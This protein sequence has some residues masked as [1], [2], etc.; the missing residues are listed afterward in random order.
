MFWKYNTLSTSQ[1]E[2]FLEKETVSLKELLELEDI[3]QE[4]KN[5]NKKLV[6]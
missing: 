2:T 4:C 5:Q 1:V 6:E 3:I